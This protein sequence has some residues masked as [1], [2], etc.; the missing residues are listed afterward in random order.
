MYKISYKEIYIFPAESLYRDY[1][2]K[3]NFADD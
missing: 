1:Y 2:E 3:E